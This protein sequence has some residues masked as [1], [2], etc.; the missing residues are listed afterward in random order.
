MTSLFQISV[1]GLLA[2]AVNAAEIDGVTVSWIGNTSPYGGAKGQ[3]K[4]WVPQDVADIAVAAD[5][6]VFTNVYW[7]EGGANQTAIRD[8]A[9]LGAAWGSRGWGHEGGDVVAVGGDWVFYSQKYD[10]EGGGLK[11]LTNW[12][13]K[14]VHWIGVSRRVRTDLGTGVAFDG[15]KG[16]KETPKGSFLPIHETSERAADISGLAVIGEELFVASTWDDTVRVFDVVT[17][18]ERRRFAVTDP[19]RMIGDA[20]GRVWIVLGDGRSVQRFDVQGAAQ[21]QPLVLPDAVQASDLAIDGKGRLLVADG[22]ISA[23]I[24]VYD[25][26]ATKPS[27]VQ[28]IGTERGML[29]GPVAGRA[30]PLRFHRIRG[31]GCDEAGNVYIASSQWPCSGTIIES[32]TP[33]LKLRWQVVGLEFVDRLCEDPADHHSLFSKETRYALDWSKPAGQEWTYAALTIDAVRFPHDPRTRLGLPSPFV[34]RINGQ[35]FLFT[36]GQNDANT[37]AVFRFDPKNAGEIAIPCALFSHKPTKKWPHEPA[38]GGFLWLDANGDGAPQADEFQAAGSELPWSGG[39]W[40]ADDGAVWFAG[41]GLRRFPLTAISAQ[42]V[43]QWDLA[44]MESM[45]APAPF[46]GVRR[47]RYD[48]ASDTMYLGGATPEHKNQHWKPMGPVVARYDGWKT[49]NREARWVAVGTYDPSYKGGHESCEP[50]SFDVAGDYVFVLLAGASGKLGIRNGTVE[51]FRADTGAVVGRL[52]N[53][54]TF[55]KAGLM[56]MVESLRAFQRAD[57]EYV[58]IIEEDHA[59]KNLLYRW[60]A[61]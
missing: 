61:P 36:H 54:P 41:G 13:P 30:G 50:I 7:E 23:Q 28:R 18:A 25:R 16:G 33:N 3:P 43:P 48:V 8:G 2:L 32:Y 10:N 6:T 56:D 47:L 24:L 55:G 49:G 57:G 45:P 51:V 53:D 31:I 42:G 9:V 14:G 26:L 5:G 29:A 34:R 35:R 19:G 15:G 39:C 58:V 52:V 21:G 44:A 59:A 20:S 38:A 46:T 17:M 11:D 60:R 1:I 40:I 27:L 4:R 37:L 22:G 12:P